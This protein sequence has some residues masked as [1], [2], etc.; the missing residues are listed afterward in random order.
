VIGQR[1]LAEGLMADSTLNL[2]M[3]V[4]VRGMIIRH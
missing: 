2:A 1:A 4:G 3:S